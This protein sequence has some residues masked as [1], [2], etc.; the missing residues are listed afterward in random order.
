MKKKLRKRRE[1]RR[2]QETECNGE[3]LRE[4]PKKTEKIL[5]KPVK[6]G[7]RYRHRLRMISTR[8]KRTRF[9]KIKRKNYIYLGSVLHEVIIPVL[10][11]H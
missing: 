7:Y 2:K 4:P 11:V 1:N 6:E 8:D 9:V 5:D 10:N 3:S